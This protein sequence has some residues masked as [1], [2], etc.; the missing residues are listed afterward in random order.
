MIKI[1]DVLVEVVAEMRAQFDKWGEQNHSDYYWFGIL[2]EEVGEASRALIENA[3]TNHVGT[4]TYDAN[5]V[6]QVCMIVERPDNPALRREL[7]QVAAV[8]LSWIECID[9]RQAFR[10]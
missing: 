3:L 4:P 1:N 6:S 2:G 7:I 5:G 9:R 10:R 8:A